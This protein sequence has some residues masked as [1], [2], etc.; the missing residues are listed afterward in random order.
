M[1][2][3]KCQP[4]NVVPFEKPWPSDILPTGKF[5]SK[6]PGMDRE[7]GHFVGEGLVSWSGIAVLNGEQVALRVGHMRN[8][9][10]FQIQGSNF[11]EIWEIE[12]SGCDIVEFF[13]KEAQIRG[14]NL[15]PSNTITTRGTHWAKLNFCGGNRTFMHCDNCYLHRPEQQ[16]RIQRQL[17]EHKKEEKE[18]QKVN[19]GAHRSP[20]YDDFLERPSQLPI[21]AV[22]DININKSSVGGFASI[23]EAIDNLM[24]L[25]GLISS[26]SPLQTGQSAPM[27]STYS[28]AFDR[29]FPSSDS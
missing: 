29:Y 23:Q 1:S 26:A 24:I 17:E 18:L 19:P 16:E 27:P 7:Y 8:A 12:E 9:S 20:F 28:E 11:V 25:K 15:N 13:L 10:T 3:E 6:L 14:T 4:E 5:L 21:R 22:G 2:T